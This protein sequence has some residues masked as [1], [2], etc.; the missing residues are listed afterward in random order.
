MMLFDCVSGMKKAQKGLALA[1]S[2][3]HCLNILVL[4]YKKKQIYAL[5]NSLGMLW[6]S[7]QRLLSLYHQTI[8]SVYS[9]NTVI[10][11]QAVPLDRKFK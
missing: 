3:N 1:H 2:Q 7:H 11:L 4:Y 8:A 6:L 9:S 5:E 10:M